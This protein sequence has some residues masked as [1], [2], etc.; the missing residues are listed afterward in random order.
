V[1]FNNIKRGLA[2]LWIV[3]AVVADLYLCVLS[4]AGLHA[5]EGSPLGSSWGVFF[6][7]IIGLNFLWFVILAALFW[8][9]NGFFLKAE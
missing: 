8:V 6:L 1:A 4:I 2:R 5:G 9:L 7:L 3:I